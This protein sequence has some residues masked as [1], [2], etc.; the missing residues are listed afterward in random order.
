MLENFKNKIEYLNKNYEKEVGGYIIGKWEKGKVIMEDLFIPEQEVTFSTIDM[1]ENAIL[2]LFKEDKDKF[3]KIIGE[4]HS[5]NSMSAFYSTTDVEDLIKPFMSGREKG[6][7]VVSSYKNNEFVHNVRIDVNSVVPFSVD[8]LEY[9]YNI[10]ENPQIKEVEEL[11]K[12]KEEEINKIKEDLDGLKDVNLNS[13]AEELKEEIKKKIKEKTYSYKQSNFSEFPSKDNVH[14][15][16]RD[17]FNDNFDINMYLYEDLPKKEINLYNLDK[18]ESN[19]V[20]GKFRKY[21]IEENQVNE[22]NYNFLLGKFKNEKHFNSAIDDIT[23][24]IEKEEYKKLDNE[25]NFE[26]DLIRQETERL[27][28]NNGTHYLDYDEEEY[29]YLNNSLSKEREMYY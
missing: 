13:V 18:K 20:K 23:Y 11:L 15:Q 12:A 22:E 19:F 1:K 3:S 28:G 7:F 17:W 25:D 21:I 6:I 26:K 27:K 24:K 16:V 4:W 5:H 29:D 9:D 14:E 2:K 10:T 8:S